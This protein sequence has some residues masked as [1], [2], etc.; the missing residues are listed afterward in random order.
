MGMLAALV[1]VACAGGTNSPTT[2]PLPT[3]APADE[4]T[5]TPKVDVVPTEKSPPTDQPP[6]E[7]ESPPGDPGEPPLI[8]LVVDGTPQEG[9]Q[10]S[11]CWTDPGAGVGLCVDK[12]PPVFDSAYSLPAGQPL[13][14]QLDVPVPDSVQLSLGEGV[15]GE[16]LVTQTLA[17]AEMLEWAVQVEPGQYILNVF[18]AWE[19]QGDVSY[20]FSISLE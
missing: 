12:I 8:R 6:V 10:G 14:L 17:G 1:L 4:S 16:P 7:A 19:Q 11:Y 15:F 20:L 13:R 3:A 18:A 2:N 5:S 9:Y